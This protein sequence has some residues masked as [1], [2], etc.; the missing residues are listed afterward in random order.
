MDKPA[1]CSMDVWMIMRECWQ[2]YPRERPTFTKIVEQLEQILSS[3][4]KDEFLD[5]GLSLEEISSDS[6][7][8][9]DD[10]NIDN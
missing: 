8:A 5:L 10:E 7:E 2:W 3:L 4:P 9:S 1:L 6:S